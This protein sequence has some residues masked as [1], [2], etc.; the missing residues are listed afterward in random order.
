M[1]EHE[2][3]VLA[4]GDVAKK[5]DPVRD[6]SPIVDRNELPLQLELAAVFAPGRHVRFEG[7]AIEDVIEER[8]EDRLL[9]IDD[10]EDHERLTDDLV[11]RAAVERAEAVVDEGDAWTGR[12]LRRR[13]DGDPLPG[14]AH[15]AAE[16]AEL[17]AGE[18][19]V[20]NVN[21]VVR[22]AWRRAERGTVVRHGDR[23]DDSSDALSSLCDRRHVEVLSRVTLAPHDAGGFIMPDKQTLQRARRD[24]R[25]GKAPSTQAGEFVSEEIEHIR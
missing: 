7:V 21:G 6:L 13:E 3:L 12:F 20:A 17:I 8:I 11:A 4:V 14:H 23:C 22:R 24:Q 25:E 9:P 5:G 16:K 2:E 18:A 15:R 10:A 19:V 1:A